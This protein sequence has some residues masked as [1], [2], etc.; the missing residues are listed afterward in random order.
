MRLLWLTAEPPDRGGGG[1]QIRQSHLLEAVGRAFEVD[2]V[3]TGG[4]PDA[5]VRAAAART[6]VV[7]RRE[8]AEPRSTTARRLRDL[9]LAVQGPPELF[10]SRGAVRALAPYAAGSDHDVVVVVHGALAPLRQAGGAGSTAHWVCE[11]QYTGSGTA[12]GVLAVTTGRRQRALYA[13]ELA[14]AERLEQRI[15]RDYDTVVCVSA[16]DAAELPGA[17][18][19]VPNGVDVGR[20][21][22]APL[23]TAPRVV[24]TGT[25]NYRPNVDGLVWF[26]REVW[27]R[28]RAQVPDAAL[29]VVGRAPVPE[30]LALADGDGVTLAVDVP[31]VRPHLDAARVAVVPLR[32]GTG[33][34]LK[35]LEAMAAGR[36]LAGTACGLAGLGLDGQAVVADDPAALAAGVVSLLRDDARAAAVA[37]AGRAHVVATAGWD[38]IGAAYVDA[39]RQRAGRP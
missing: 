22:P 24:F 31:D 1:G 2:L 9:R 10:A 18:L 37:A 36:A 6:T 21:S 34:R 26:R 29:E 4:E 20:F 3:V 14:L 12:R 13:R 39:L 8:P 17:T 19:V 30:V 35:A 28:V 7:P 11:Q 32:L 23:P 5:H 38:A 25:L 33:T 27:P 15:G 16:E